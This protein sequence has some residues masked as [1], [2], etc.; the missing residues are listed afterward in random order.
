MYHNDRTIILFALST[1]P[2]GTFDNYFFIEISYY[3][4]EKMNNNYSDRDASGL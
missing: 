3:S 4:K 2:K 1:S